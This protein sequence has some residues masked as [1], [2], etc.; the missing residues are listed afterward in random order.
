MR[1]ARK[2]RLCL[3]LAVFGLLVTISH[4]TAG[5][6][7]AGTQRADPQ[8]PAEEK[9]AD[10]QAPGPEGQQP[11]APAP[12]Q[13]EAKPGDQGKKAQEN[14]TQSGTSKDRLFFLLPNFLTLENAAQVPPLTTGQKFKLEARS[15]FDP[16]QFSYYFVLA[17]INQAAN[18]EA[19]Y[20]QGA[21]GYGK[22]FGAIFADSTIE[23][24]MVGAAF[25]S[26]LRQDPRYFQKGKGGFG[27]RTWYA[28][29]RIFVTRGD[30]GHAQFNA[31]E[32]FGSAIAAGIST[33]SYH[34]EA[35][36]QF[37]NV[38]GTWG[39]QLGLDSF[40]FMMKEFWPDIRRFVKRKKS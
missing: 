4:S 37:G 33:Y 3:P 20:G 18:A 2:G 31:S 29:T 5:Q 14:Q 7:A 38:V 11:S 16:V 9:A 22:R 8:K 35:D 24:V 36:R 12:G 28:L 1:K 15:T 32:I 25:P 27:R 6:Q 17:G 39:T 19:G 26:L 10:Q 13:G 23:N 34:P 40:S 30:S 21:Q